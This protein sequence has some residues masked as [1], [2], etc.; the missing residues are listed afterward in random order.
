MAQAFDERKLATM[1]EPVLLSDQVGVIYAHAWFSVSRTGV[2][3]YYPAPLGGTYAL[4]W[5]D[6]DGNRSDPIDTGYFEG[7]ALSPDGTK[8][9]VTVP[10]TEQIGVDLWGFDLIRGTK[11]RLTA[12]PGINAAP[13]WQPDGRFI[14]FG[15]TTKGQHQHIYR[16][17][18]DG[19]GTAETVFE[20]DDAD[21]S[22]WSVCRDG[23]YLAYMA[24]TKGSQPSIWALPLA[25]DGKP[26]A[27]V[28]SQFLNTK[29]AF[30]PDCKWIAYM[31]NETG[32]IETY[33]THFPDAARRYRVSTQ[34]GG[35]PRWRGD[36]KELFYFSFPQNSI[37]AVNVD[38]NAEE[39]SLGTPRTLFRITNQTVA[40]TSRAFAVTPDGR[41]F[42]I[43]ELNS[44]SGT[45]PL[46]LV[47]NWDAEL[48]KR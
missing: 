27:L 23:R 40:R 15:S 6:R 33:I 46:T 21:K 35:E 30:S 10:D 22:P 17:R 19:I 12:M 37:M 2:L 9:V 13:V 43:T 29:P 31:S 45:V 3:V 44:P 47:T 25:G 39:I 18:S 41:R 14:L 34:G 16:I 28:R 24:I 11:T 7:P 5:Y 26:F 1:G 8:A 48:K 42:L 38:E 36:G 32:Q 20:S 4:F